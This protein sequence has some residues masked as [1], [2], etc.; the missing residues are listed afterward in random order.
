MRLHGKRRGE[1]PFFSTRQ[2]LRKPEKERQE[3]K[4][5]RE[6]ER[7]KREMISQKLVK[8][9]VEEKRGGGVNPQCHRQLMDKGACES[10]LRDQTHFQTHRHQTHEGKEK[11][12]KGRWC[13]WVGRVH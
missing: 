6:G 3:G 4:E 10:L 11:D 1:T 12:E 13:S 8:K 2:R 9:Q 5:E 7:G